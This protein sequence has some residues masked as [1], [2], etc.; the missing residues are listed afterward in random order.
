MD[1]CT[2]KIC[3]TQ[4]V[5]AVG[6][7]G[8]LCTSAARLLTG[9]LG[10]S[11]GGDNGSALL[12]SVTEISFPAA[13]AVND[14]ARRGLKLLKYA[15]D[16][17]DDKTSNLTIARIARFA[18]SLWRAINGDCAPP[19]SGTVLHDMKGPNGI[20]AF[21][22][23][24]RCSLLSLLQWIW[25]SRCKAVLRVQAWGPTMTKQQY[26]QL[27]ADTV[28]LST[29]TEN[30]AANE[31]GESLAAINHI[32]E[33]EIDRQKWR[34]EMASKAFEYHEYDKSRK[35]PDA[36]VTVVGIG[37]PLRMVE[38]DTAFRQGGWIAS[39]AQQ[40]R[41]NEDDGGCKKVIRLTMKS[42]SKLE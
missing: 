38:R 25:P 29:E 31:E 35:A 8:D 10:A 22:G 7:R 13:N 21:D 30:E 6:G 1:A 3:S 12:M 16:S 4:R 34:G 33:K 11:Y 14:G 39:A 27:G 9:P 17:E 37:Q 20:C 36:T 18:T 42:S 5:G 15:G 40:R 32:V 41:A 24:L 28:M 23:Q 26:K 19:P 2:G